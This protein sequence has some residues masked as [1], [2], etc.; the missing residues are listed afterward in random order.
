MKANEL[1]I[2]DWVRSPKNADGDFYA[3]QVCEIMQ[4]EEH[5]YCNIP[6][7]DGNDSIRCDYL[8]PIPLTREILEKNGWKE[9]VLRHW[10]IEEDFALE[11]GEDGNMFWF[12]RGVSLVCSLN[13]VHELQHALRLCGVEKEITL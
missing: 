7:P 8:S 6:G 3:A 10:N 1:M 4:G 5:Y 11:K 12:L 13:F 2:G 9:A